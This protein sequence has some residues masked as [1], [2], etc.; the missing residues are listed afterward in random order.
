MEYH[1]YIS[2]IPESLVVSMLPAEEFGRYLAVGTKKR[3]N[4]QAIFFELSNDFE[5]EHFDL[6][7][8]IEL[9]KPHEDGQPKHSVY[10]STY[11][12]LEHVSLEAIGS[13][14]LV[15]S[16]GLTLELKQAPLPTK[17]EE[18]H[19]LYQELCPVHP[20]IA[21][22]LDPSEFCKFIT[23]PQER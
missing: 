9:C 5:S 16:N 2:L 10:V 3:A 15:T 4:E 6:K 19:H 21:S 17:T 23:D 18:I 22:T 11:R 7:G 12:V 13:L 1:L 14:W 8:A 20:L